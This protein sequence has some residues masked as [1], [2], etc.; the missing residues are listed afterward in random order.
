VILQRRDADPAVTAAIAAVRPIRQAAVLIPII[1]RSEP[2][3]LFT[4]RTAQ[5]TDHAGQI[6]FPGGKIEA[7]DESPAA[8]ALRETEEEIA[9]ARRF[10]EPFGYLTFT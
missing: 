3:V 2:S 8:T 9:L 5:L 7:G 4:R 10:I 6:S 1:E